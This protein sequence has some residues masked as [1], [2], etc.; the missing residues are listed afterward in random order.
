M[1][2][3]RHLQYAPITEALIDIHVEPRPGLTFDEL[4]EAITKS[5]FGYY[6]KGSI[7]Q[8]RFE[9]KLA[10]DGQTPASASHSAQIG[11]R[12]HSEDEKYVAQCRL[13]GFTLSR[14]HPYENLSGVGD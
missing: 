1:A 13:S 4:K 6:E 14:V 8:S 12:M 3:I 2:K 9:F 7:A 11:V 10:S 5:D